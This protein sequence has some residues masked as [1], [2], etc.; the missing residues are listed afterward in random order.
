MIK[1]NKRDVSSAD[2]E[3]IRWKVR[4]A[5]FV[6]TQRRKH[7]DEVLKP[8]VQ[9]NYRESWGNKIN[10]RKNGKRAK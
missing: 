4:L 5:D 6:I 9:L 1:K 10:T 7:L 8:V 3:K 2:P